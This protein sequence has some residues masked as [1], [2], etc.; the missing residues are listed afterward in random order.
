M[1]E[2]YDYWNKRTPFTWGSYDDMRRLRYELAPYMHELFQFDKWSG[3]R[4]LEVGSGSGIDALEYAKNG[5]LVYATDMTE[6]A[7][8]YINNLFVEQN[9]KPEKIEMA[10]GEHLPYD[11]G[12]FDLVYS[13]GVVHH[14]REDARIVQEMHRVLKP[15]G[16][17][18]IVV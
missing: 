16:K 13:F 11:D 3:K 1:D 5:A 6:N 12:F 15:G 7:V 18:Y 9:I 14:S 2:I 17:C 4:V 8:N 10:N